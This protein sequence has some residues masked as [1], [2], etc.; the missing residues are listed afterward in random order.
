MPLH[1]RPITD[2][3]PQRRVPP[4]SDR[5][6]GAFHAIGDFAVGG[7]VLDPSRPGH[8][9]AVEIRADG[10][11]LGLV[12][13]ESFSAEVRSR[14]GG[15]GC[16]GFTFV[17]DAEQLGAT[18]VIEAVVAN[19][20][21]VIGAVEW[22]DRAEGETPSRAV[23][24]ELL[25]SGGL[26]VSGF[27]HDLAD[28]GR[29]VA[30]DVFVDGD[31]VCRTVA[32]TWRDMGHETVVPSGRIGFDVG[33]PL[34]LAD[35]EAH[36]VRVT[37]QGLDLDGSP[38]V[39]L[40]H[41]AG[42]AGLASAL[43]PDD[44]TGLRTRAT[45]LDRLMP[46]ALPL[47]DARSWLERFPVDTPPAAMGTMAVLIL[48]GGDDHAAVSLQSLERQGHTRWL[49]LHVPADDRRIDRDAFAQAR[50][51][52]VDAGVD[53]V[54]VITAGAVLDAQAIGHMAAALEDTAA[55]GLVYPDVVRIVD[56]RPVPVAFPAYD[57]FRMRAQG[58]CVDLFAV[59]AGLFETA[60][61]SGAASGYDLLLSCLRAC[62]ASGD[63]I[64]HLPQFLA[65]TPPPG[66]E[67]GAQALAEAVRSDLAVRSPGTDIA[68]EA[69]P[70]HFFPAVAC[71][72]PAPGDVP[73]VTIVIPTRDRL[74]LLQPCIDSL[75]TRT[76]DVDF[77]ILVVD[78]GSRD[79]ETIAYFAALEA[80]GH[81]VL[82]A[83]IPFNYSRLNNM[84]VAQARHDLV[85]L[86]NNDVEVIE[87]G[88][89]AEMTSL[90]REDGVGIVGA[91]LLWPSRIVQHG[92]VVVGP[93]LAARHAFNSCLD[94]EAGY[95]D[96]L[97][98]ERQ[99]S[100]VTAACLL[101]S[102]AD[103]EAVGGLDEVAFPVTFNDVDLCLKVGATG[104]AVV[105][106]P[107]ARL[108]HKESASRGLDVS[109]EKNAR[110][111]KE[112]AALRDRWGALLVDDPFYNPNLGLDLFPFEGLATPP[113]RRALRLRKPGP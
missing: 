107:N 91:T 26:R 62:E 93:H 43:D 46:A 48:G 51:E 71:R 79:P 89:L 67:S 61:A 104:K 63:A 27:A 58:Y 102:R 5:P 16:H 18:R 1:A 74:D 39:M 81:S 37:A 85:C 38:T 8:R 24:G 3:D 35:G 32:D 90:L 13:A 101:I 72:R 55:P 49:A 80:V 25:W 57:R 60:S 23:V 53:G 108:L 54:I 86:L 31:L 106:S 87:D 36:V 4:P 78:N 7:W 28:P 88:W 33:L 19:S 56:G 41:E 95:G 103:Y 12:L 22:R 42:F 84:A 77:E 94:G 47:S 6:V 96:M 15:D 2:D 75:L 66:L 11:H 99:H 110:A 73:R 20:D 44:R 105:M 83:D 59:P 52:L 45:L 112:T 69:G 17:L 98:V 30:I 100:A 65:V 111:R 113:R 10:E 109:R 21:T 76:R 34:S 29:P 92:G 82:R 40:V 9:F 70:G 97:L 14:F 50:D 68:V 64:A